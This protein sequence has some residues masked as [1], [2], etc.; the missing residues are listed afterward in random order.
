MYQEILTRLGY[1][2]D[3][4]VMHPDLVAVNMSSYPRFVPD[5]SLV[6]SYAEAMQMGEEFPPIVVDIDGVLIDGYHRLLA[7]KIIKSDKIGVLK[8][9]KKL[10][11]SERFAVAVEL[12]L[13]HGKG[14]VEQDK[15][16]IMSYFQRVSYPDG[17]TMSALFNKFVN[18]TVTDDENVSVNTY[19]FADNDIVL[20][21]VPIP[22]F[23]D[24]PAEATDI[25]EK[26]LEKEIENSIYKESMQS[27]NMS[28][29]N[30]DSEVDKFTVEED[31]KD[32]ERELDLTDKVM[33]DAIVENIESFVAPVDM[34]DIIDDTNAA[35]ISNL[36]QNRSSA[37][38]DKYIE[39]FK[40]IENQIIAFAS[41]SKTMEIPYEVV[42]TSWTFILCHLFAFFRDIILVHHNKCDVESFQK[43]LQCIIDVLQKSGFSNENIMHVK[44]VMNSARTILSRS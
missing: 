38:I 42:E 24:V 25:K 22:D 5:D 39:A 26:I 2:F 18:L 9:K 32:I 1:Q 30:S 36:E 37:N 20:P 4:E 21:D 29:A 13:R 16:K 33:S 3:D 41:K 31:L 40:K 11:D 10:N 14:F 44:G 28:F 7:A 17:I 34:N 35:V 23:F 43:M 6:H 19:I 12:N 27:E 15:E 8:I